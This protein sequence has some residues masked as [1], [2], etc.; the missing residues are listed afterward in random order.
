MNNKITLKIRANQRIENDTLVN[1]KVDT[2][3]LWGDEVTL[4]FDN[5]DYCDI[6]IKRNY[7]TGRYVTTWESVYAA[8]E[9]I[10]L[11]KIGY[12]TIEQGK[13]ELKSL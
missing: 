2:T 7:S 12:I 3:A 1:A 5:G 10:R 13:V 9:F 8:D 4:Y 6:N 11:L